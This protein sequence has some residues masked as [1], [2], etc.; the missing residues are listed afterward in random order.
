MADQNYYLQKNEEKHAKSKGKE[1]PEAGMNKFS[2]DG[3]FLELFKKQMEAKQ[4]AMSKISDEN[5]QS[6]SSTSPTPPSSSTSTSESSSNHRLKT[7]VL[8]MVSSVL[9][10]EICLASVFINKSHVGALL[11]RHHN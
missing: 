4:Y 11:V 2:N 8:P 3:S 6:Q 10:S 9:M 5:N 7:P 1:S